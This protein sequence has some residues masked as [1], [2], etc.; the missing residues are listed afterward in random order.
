MSAVLQF[1]VCM[2]FAGSQKATM[3]AF[4]PFMVAVATLTPI[5]GF[6]HFTVESVS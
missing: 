2:A 6:E 4:D 3:I 1:F 5:P